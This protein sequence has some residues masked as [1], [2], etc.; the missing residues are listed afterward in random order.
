MEVYEKFQCGCKCGCCC[1]C[2]CKQNPQILFPV[3]SYQP[4]QTIVQ[5]N[6]KYEQRKKKYKNNLNNPNN[7]YYNVRAENIKKKQFTFNLYCLPYGD[8][9]PKIP[10]KTAEL[11]SAGLIKGLT[12]SNDDLNDEI[13]NAI[14]ELFPC[15][16]GKTWR[17]FRCKTTSDLEVANE[18]EI[19]WNAGA[20][21]MLKKALFQIL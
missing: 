17:F 1:V 11:R 14:E 19:G 4:Y 2:G 13:K 12:I 20:L 7:P 6:S 8:L 9:S 15:L 18:P 16:K 21:K 3:A 5:S 10:R